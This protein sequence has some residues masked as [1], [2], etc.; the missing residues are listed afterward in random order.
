[1]S[2]RTPDYTTYTIKELYEVQTWIDA[3]HY[4]DRARALREEIEKRHRVIRETQPQA[5]RHGRSISRYTIAA[6][7]MSGGLYGS[8]AAVS[9]IWRIL[10]VMQERSERP[11]LS[12]LVHLTFGA[13]FAMSLAAGV[14]LWRD[15][16]L[17]WLLSKLTQAL[18]VVQ[19]QVLGAGY[20]FAVGAAILVQ[21]HG[22][23]VGLSAR[24]GND[25]RFS[26]GAGG[27]GFNLDINTL[28]LVF[29]SALIELEKAGREPPPPGS[30]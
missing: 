20:A 10:V 9:A 11:L 14:L 17:G 16:P 22:G 29:L 3:E 4:P 30:S 13:L 12:C 7:Q 24:L 6:F 18:Q 26:A 25:Y 23:E 5:H 19:F 8:V 27:H 1:M 2:E 21:V 15:R 28:A